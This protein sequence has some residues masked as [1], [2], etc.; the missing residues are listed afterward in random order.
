MIS[1][2]EF[3]DTTV[4]ELDALLTYPRAILV[5][6]DFVMIFKSGLTYVAQAASGFGEPSTST[7]HMRQLPATDSLS[8]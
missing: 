6:S 8:W 1:E 5:R 4:F 7:K 3:H 2:Q